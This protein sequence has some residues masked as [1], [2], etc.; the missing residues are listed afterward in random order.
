MINIKFSKDIYNCKIPYTD[1]YLLK[2]IVNYPKNKLSTISLTN[3]IGA[4]YPL[5]SR[6]QNIITHNEL[7]GPSRAKICHWEQISRLCQGK[8]YIYRKGR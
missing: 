6:G 3:F 4:L 5:K 8:R 2:R 1:N 7:N